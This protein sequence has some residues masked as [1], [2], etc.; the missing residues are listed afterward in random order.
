[1]LRMVQVDW[2]SRA[3]A[4]VGLLLLSSCGG[5]GGGSMPTEPGGPTTKTVT[6]TIADFSFTPKDVTLNPGDS[7]TW[8]LAGTDYMHSATAEDGS[9]NSGFIFTHTGATFTQ[10]FPTGGKTIQYHCMTHWHTNGMEG[11]IRVGA[12]SPPPAPGY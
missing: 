2:L 10:T 7:V 11:S 1:M 5:G 8:V 6:V 4:A 9:F 12:N 3:A